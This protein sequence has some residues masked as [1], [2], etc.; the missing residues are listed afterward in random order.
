MKKFNL[1]LLL[2]LLCCG[3]GT[4]SAQSIFGA[5]VVAG[6]NISQM[7][8]DDEA[9][10]NK[11]GLHGGLKASIYLGPRTEAGIGIQYDQ[12]GSR[13]ALSRGNTGLPFKISI[14]YI[15]VPVTYSFKDWYDEDEGYY[16]IHFTGGL[17]YGRL[18]RRQQEGS[19][20]FD[21]CLNDLR[22]NDLSWLLG[23]TYYWSEHWGASAFHLRSIL[24]TN[25][26]LDICFKDLRPYQW[27]FRV[28]YRF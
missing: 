2:F 1:Y 27:T 25:P 9:G 16:K 4:S 13:N 22:D 23:V 8:G 3:A 20:I 14:D 24:D 18:F 7:T 5:S 6:A 19:R 11:I 17:S 28:E 26:D 15:T 10:F 12:R 21:E